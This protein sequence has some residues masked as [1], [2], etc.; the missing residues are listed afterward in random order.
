MKER[1]LVLEEIGTLALGDGFDGER[2]I[3]LG[4]RDEGEA[5]ERAQ[6]VQLLWVDIS[7]QT[8]S[9]DGAAASLEFALKADKVSYQMQGAVLERS[10]RHRETSFVA[11][12]EDAYE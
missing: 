9:G 2:N 12:I 6:E 3:G 8:K 1:E 4:D 5:E 10:G 7:S 11:G